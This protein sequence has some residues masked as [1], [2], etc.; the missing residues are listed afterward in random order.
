MSCSH[1]EV[2][3]GLYVPYFIQVSSKVLVRIFIDIC[4]IYKKI[5][6]KLQIET[7]STNLTKSIKTIIHNSPWLVII[8][9][10]SVTWAELH[11]GGLIFR[12]GGLKPPPQ[13][14]AWLRPWGLRVKIRTTA[15]RS[16]TII[17]AG[18]FTIFRWD[19]TY[20]GQLQIL[21]IDVMLW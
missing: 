12:L 3:L 8:L 6:S 9:A 20:T 4:K 14:H 10:H 13:A 1:N 21:Q 11:L 16:G 2:S 18:S 15:Y 19:N 5:K 17:A 7:K